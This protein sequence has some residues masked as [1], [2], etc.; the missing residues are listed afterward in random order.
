MAKKSCERQIDLPSTNNT[1][2]NNTNDSWNDKKTN[3]HP[4]A[5]RGF[6]I[7]RPQIR[8]CQLHSWPSRQHCGSH[9][10]PVRQMGRDQLKSGRICTCLAESRCKWHTKVCTNLRTGAAVSNADLRDKETT[11]NLS[12]L[13]KIETLKFENFESKIKILFFK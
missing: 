5:N 4:H 8:V 9:R 10:K 6:G 1:I 3:S 2:H 13:L 7:Q 12:N 11:D